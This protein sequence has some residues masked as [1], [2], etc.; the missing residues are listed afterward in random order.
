LQLPF[1]LYGHQLCQP[2]FGVAEL[3]GLY[4]LTG[5]LLKPQF[6]QVFFLPQNCLG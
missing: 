3:V 2:M 5:R 1:P 6:K 4:G